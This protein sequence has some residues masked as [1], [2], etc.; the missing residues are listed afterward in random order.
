MN[1]LIVRPGA[2]GDTL[3]LMPSMACLREKV[4]LTFVGRRPGLDFLQ[5]HVSAC[6]DFEGPG[7]HRLF[8]EMPDDHGLPICQA[9]LVVAFFNDKD[10][11]IRHNLNTFL[12]NVPVHVFSSLPPEGATIHAA[13]YIAECLK[14]SGLPIEPKKSIDCAVRGFLFGAICPRTRRS[15]FVFH[16]GSGDS[17]KNH[18]PEFWLNLILRVARTTDLQG[19]KHT[20]LLGP[21]EE[22]LYPFFIENLQSSKVKIL[23]Y[24]EKDQ[25]TALLKTAALYFGHDSGITHLAAMS[26][27]PTLALFKESDVNQ[28]RPLGP[29]V[30]VIRSNAHSS[31]MIIG[32]V[33]KTAKDLHFL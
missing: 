31:G 20:I 12:P 24:P 9:D 22:A 4:S 17:R 2:L 10:G 13:L 18:P 28:W 26:G 5:T 30:R 21:A 6:L 23:V 3:M 33:L 14:S 25:L 19:H 7:W 32:E 15:G 16:P 1:V 27:T 8:L 11:R 29:C